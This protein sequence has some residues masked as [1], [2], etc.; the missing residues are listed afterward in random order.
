MGEGEKGEE[1]EDNICPHAGES[2]GTK[3][4]PGEKKK[5]QI[6][7]ALALGTRRV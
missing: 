1:E 2:G 5:K 6:D 7:Y 3:K 4:Q